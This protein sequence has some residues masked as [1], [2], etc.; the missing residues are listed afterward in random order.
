MK[1]GFSK[2]LAVFMCMAMLACMFSFVGSAKSLD[3]NFSPDTA[4][5][6]EGFSTLFASEKEEFELNSVATNMVAP[7]AADADISFTWVDGTGWCVT[8][9]KDSYTGTLEIEANVGFATSASSGKVTGISKAAFS[10]SKVSK[11]IIPGTVVDIDIS[12]FVGCKELEEIVVDPSNPNYCSYNGVLYNKAKTELIYVPAKAAGSDF[13]IPEGVKTVAMG[14]FADCSD[15]AL[16][17]PSTLNFQNSVDFL[18]VLSVNEFKVNNN[19]YVSVKDGVLM[20]KRGSAIIKYPIDSTRKTYT[21]P[22][23][24]KETSMLAFVSVNI[25]AE[26]A[27]A[28]IIPF[29]NGIKALSTP[30]NL[31][32]IM[33]AYSEDYVSEIMEGVMLGCT[34]FAFCHEMWTKDFVNETNAEYAAYRAELQA[35]LDNELAQYT[36]GSAEYMELKLYGDYLLMTMSVHLTYWTAH[37]EPDCYEG[38]DSFTCFCGFRHTE[39]IPAI[40]HSFS[41]W[42]VN[43]NGYTRGCSVCNNANAEIFAMNTPSI[44]QVK[45]GETLVLHLDSATDKVPDGC[46]VVWEISGSGATVSPAEDGMTCNVTCVDNETV[47]VTAKLINANTH[48]PT[49]DENGNEVG[50]SQELTMK[51]GFFWKIISFFKN[52]FGISRIIAQAV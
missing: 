38:S 15:F 14:A 30:S 41:E 24:V 4:K 13:A 25:D 20:D 47:T 9:V 26:L 36:P 22:E 21:I 33:Q 51:G 32:V 6:N 8:D 46:A 10:G 52:L 16:T 50:V 7:T 44:T 37:D 17:I 39:P 23:G 45:Y 5:L 28:G 31:F 11:V 49:Y 2:T 1:K 40:G 29:R 27:I 12:A 18:E 48:N 43:G 35:E 42:K 34:H 19:P 3:F